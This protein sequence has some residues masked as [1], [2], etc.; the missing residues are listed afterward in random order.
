[1]S[2]GARRC[3]VHT[4]PLEGDISLLMADPLRPLLDAD[5]CE[6]QVSWQYSSSGLL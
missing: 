6:V 4:L 2:P 3:H 1:M 5:S